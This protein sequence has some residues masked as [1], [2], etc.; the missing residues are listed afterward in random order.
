ME[1]HLHQNA[2]DIFHNVAK[3]HSEQKDQKRLI[4]KRII[5]KNRHNKR[6]RAVNRTHGTGEKAAVDYTLF[7][8]GTVKTFN[9]P[10][11]GAVKEE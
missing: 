7:A 3:H 5:K 9:K 11:G 10:T 6:A 1:K 4:L 8:N 2:C